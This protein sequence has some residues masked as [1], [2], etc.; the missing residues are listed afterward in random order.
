MSVSGN[1][2]MELLPEC[3]KADRNEYRGC[4]GTPENEDTE[5]YTFQDSIRVGIY[6]NLK[7]YFA[8]M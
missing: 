2:Q 1:L 8:K 7:I 6:E 4:K 5:K 3:I